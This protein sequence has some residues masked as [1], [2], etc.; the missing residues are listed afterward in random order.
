MGVGVD[1]SNV[2]SVV[3]PVRDQGAC[4]SCYAFAS[5][6]S[7]EAALGLAGMGAG[8]QSVQNIVD[9]SGSAGNAGCSGGS[10]GG[11]LNWVAQ[12]RGLCAEAAYPYRGVESVCAA[13]ACGARLATQG[14]GAVKGGSAAAFEA[15][16]AQNPVAVAVQAA[17][18]V[19]QLYASG[20]VTSA[21]GTNLDHAVLLVGFG[22]GAGGDYYKI[23]NSWGAAWGE[24]GYIRLARGESYGPLGQCGVQ[25]QGFFATVVV[26]SDASS[27]LPA[28]AGAGA[29][30]G[31]AP[32]GLALALGLGLG[33]AAALL[34]GAAT[35]VVARRKGRCG[36]T[37]RADAK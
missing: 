18:S 14:Y 12:Q 19:W 7:V 15:A 16:L 37:A 36:G 17:G 32:P 31:S 24:G 34:A 1:W 25:S 29:A 30:A 35:V 20:V 9:C 22:T 21:C 10:I 4:G 13:A 2:G 33:G 11:T 6:A 28:L 3:L 5:A 26:G 23:K 8:Y 27:P